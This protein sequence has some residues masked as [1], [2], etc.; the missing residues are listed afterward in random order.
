[1]RRCGAAKIN[2]ENFEFREF[3]RRPDAFVLNLVANITMKNLIVNITQVFG[4]SQMF[5]FKKTILNRNIS[6]VVYHKTK[7]FHEFV[8]ENVAM[9]TKGW[10]KMFG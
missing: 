2:W 10:L 3:R 1:M 4:T 8:E 9:E 6:V 5:C 7:H